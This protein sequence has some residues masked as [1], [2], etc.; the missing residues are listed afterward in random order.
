MRYRSGVVIAFPDGE[1]MQAAKIL[2]DEAYRE[3][4]GWTESVCTSQHDGNHAPNSWHYARLD[5]DERYPL[6]P[7]GSQ[8]GI[9]L[10]TWVK[11]NVPMQMSRA[12]KEK[13]AERWLEKLD[14]VM[15]GEWF[16]QVESDHIH[17]HHRPERLRPSQELRA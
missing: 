9:D 6:N 14:A 5:D 17:G 2:A 16:V 10:R 7:N 13:I 15:P 4:V 11:P 1:K 8:G 3:I 12:L